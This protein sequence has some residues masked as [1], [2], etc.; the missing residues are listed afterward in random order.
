[1]FASSAVAQA[2]SRPAARTANVALENDA[3]LVSRVRIA[4]HEKTGMPDQR[5]ANPVLTVALTDENIRLTFAGGRAVV[6]RRRA[7]ETH[8]SEAGEA[9]RYT[10]ENLGAAPIEELRV[11]IKRTASQRAVNS[12]PSRRPLITP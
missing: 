6:S 11:E 8:W 5:A 4:P 7:G 3:V 1:L 2:T 9:S 10:V 12:Q